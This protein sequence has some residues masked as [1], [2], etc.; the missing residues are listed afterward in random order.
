LEQLSL[1][2]LNLHTPDVLCAFLVGSAVA[3]GQACLLM[4]YLLLL[5][6]VRLACQAHLPYTPMCLGKLTALV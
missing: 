4:A 5:R 1:D 2:P 3:A 6:R